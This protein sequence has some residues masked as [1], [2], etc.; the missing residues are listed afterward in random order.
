MSNTSEVVQFVERLARV[1]SPNFAVNESVKHEY[2]SKLGRYRF[3]EENWDT[4][5][6]T[7][8]TEDIKGMPALA[9]IYVIANQVEASIRNA[10]ADATGKVIFRKDGYDFATLIVLRNGRWVVAEGRSQGTEAKEFVKR[11]KGAVLV[12]VFPSKAAY[13]RPEEILSADDPFVLEMNKKFHELVAETKNL[14]VNKLKILAASRA[15]A[16]EM[17]Q[18]KKSAYWY[19]IEDSGAT[20]GPTTE[21]GI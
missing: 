9:V 20:T 10:N 11:I 2:I 18:N 7:L 4:V 19:A 6:E 12:G 14:T 3:T 17:R 16:T 5:L 21:G 8:C 1:T 15:T 13:P